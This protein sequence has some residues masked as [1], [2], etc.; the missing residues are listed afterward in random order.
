MEKIDNLLSRF[1][2]LTPPNISVRNIVC[3]LIKSDFNFKIDIEKI[4]FNQKTGLITLQI[5]NTEKT[6]IFLKK[7]ELIKKANN[8]L[9]KE[10]IKDIN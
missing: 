3:S 9:K 5:N 4:L 1:K 6:A 8:N 7:E 10:V 2:K